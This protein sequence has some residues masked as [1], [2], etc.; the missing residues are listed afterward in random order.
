MVMLMSVLLAA[1]AMLSDD[2]VL[3]SDEAWCN[4]QRPNQKA[5]IRVSVDDAG[6]IHVDPDSCTVAPGAR[7]QWIAPKGSRFEVVFETDSPD[8][9][10][11]LKIASQSTAKEE[12]ISIRALRSDTRRSF[13][14][15]VVLDGEVL[16]P[17][18]IIDP[19][20]R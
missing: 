16:D 10:G 15:D 12:R 20:L 5:V 13:T 1:S 7:L 17:V 9:T 11:K 19:T 8:E 3:A 6:T 2:M 4:T 18:V 14:Y